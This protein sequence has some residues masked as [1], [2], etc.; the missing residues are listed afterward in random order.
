[1]TSGP[2]PPAAPQ[3]LTG[4]PV[5]HAQPISGKV[6][7]PMTLLLAPFARTALLPA[8]LAPPPKTNVC[9]VQITT[10]LPMVL[11]LLIS[12][13]THPNGVVLVPGAHS[14][15]TS[16]LVVPIIPALDTVLAT[17]GRTLPEHVIVFLVFMALRAAN[18]VNA[19]EARATIQQQ[20]TGNVLR[21]SLPSMDRHAVKNV[22]VMGVSAMMEYL[23]GEIVPATQI[24]M[25]LLVPK[26]ANV[27][28]LML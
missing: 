8:S 13:A 11:A 17:V 7:R 23:V 3:A 25:A 27:T 5:N 9:C 19:M 12:L 6:P 10:A 4:P 21:A 18:H 15:R 16:A 20:E 2:C 22:T 28:Y 1:M 14:A 24:L 26:H